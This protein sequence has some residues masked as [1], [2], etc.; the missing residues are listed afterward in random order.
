M[1]ATRVL[2]VDDELGMRETLCDILQDAGYEVSAAHDGTSALAEVQ[3]QAFDVVLMD[4]RMPGPDGVTVLQ[5]MG[6]PPP[7][8][9]MMTAYAVEDQLRRAMDAQA[10]AVVHKPFQVGYLLNLVEGA[11]ESPS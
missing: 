2:V 9:I 5:Q 3:G 6:P 8:V 11:A 10:F 4:I 7:R 1:T